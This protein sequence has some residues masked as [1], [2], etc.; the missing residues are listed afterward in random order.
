MLSIWHLP[1]PL[2]A[3]ENTLFLSLA[4]DVGHLWQSI[5]LGIK[6]VQSETQTG[7]A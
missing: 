2:E 6:V 7:A 3:A 5:G 1:A 4:P